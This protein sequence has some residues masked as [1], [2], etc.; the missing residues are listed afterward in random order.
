MLFSMRHIFTVFSKGALHLCNLC[1]S[2]K[3]LDHYAQRWCCKNGCYN[4][5]CM[6]QFTFFCNDDSTWFFIEALRDYV[7]SQQ[8]LPFWKLKE[9][10]FEEYL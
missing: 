6:R 5:I 3:Y 7:V 2:V 9:T 1:V 4:K 10:V 8:T